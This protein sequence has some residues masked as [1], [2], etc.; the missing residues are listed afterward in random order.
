M[1]LSKNPQGGE[2]IDFKK[3]CATF[4]STVRNFHD[5]YQFGKGAGGN[6]PAPGDNQSQVSQRRTRI[7]RSR[8]RKR[9]S[10][11]TPSMSN[12]KSIKSGPR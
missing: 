12:N 4:S 10:R 2:Y 7:L 6:P 8:S 9:S 3:S 5:D 11:A 1:S